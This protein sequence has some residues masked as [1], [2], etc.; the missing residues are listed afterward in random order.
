MTTEQYF[1]NVPDRVVR[2]LGAY[3]SHHAVHM[4]AAV[5]ELIVLR[6]LSLAFTMPNHITPTTAFLMPLA[7]LSRC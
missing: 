1:S 7:K 6:T 2:Y 3:A 4:L 5:I